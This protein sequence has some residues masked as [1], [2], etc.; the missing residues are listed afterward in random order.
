VSDS[1]FFLVEDLRGAIKDAGHV[2]G[3]RTGLQALTSGFR[4]RVLV[5]QSS[6]YRSASDPLVVEIQGRI[7]CKDG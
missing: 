6:E 5:D 7:R 1:L 4:W 2:W 3:S